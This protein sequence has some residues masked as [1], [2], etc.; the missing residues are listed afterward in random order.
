M[1]TAK[2]VLFI[3]C[4]D[5]HIRVF[6]PIIRR[7]EEH[8]TLAPLVVFLKGV[9]GDMLMQFL[10]EHRLR[11]KI[12]DLSSRPVKTA[13]EAGFMRRFL[14]AVKFSRCLFDINKKVKKLFD[15][16]NPVLVIATNVGFN[17]SYFFYQ[18][19]K[20]GIPSLYVPLMMYSTALETEITNIR[21]SSLS[22]EIYKRL[23]ELLRL[24]VHWVRL[25][26][27]HIS[28]IVV[29]SENHKQSLVE[30]GVQADR[31][32]VTGSPAHDKIF[33]QVRNQ[34]ESDS[35][36]I[37]QHLAIEKDKQIILYTSQPTAIHEF[38]T[39]EEQRQ[40]TGNI[41]KACSRFTPYKLVIKLHPRESIDDYKYLK[42]HPLRDNFRVVSEKDSDLYDLLYIARLV[43]TQSSSTGLD[44]ILFDKDM[45]V[46]D[47]LSPV[48]D[49]MSYIKSGAAL[50]VYKED[51]LLPTLERVLSDT[52]IQQ[53][54]RAK[55]K[56]FAADYIYK[57]DGESAGR[58]LELIHTMIYNE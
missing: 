18:A 36:R 44:A 39:V 25:D 12:L 56:K 32:V 3:P 11:Y 26:K 13:R 57:A 23:Q 37:Y 45:I 34:S 51:D 8:H 16:L 7:M 29:W 55:R 50:G 42:N 10:N 2:N 47:Y 15:K 24:P 28:K 35:T 1:K 9:H 43:V 48:Q 20:R 4:Y 27:G 40:F 22:E 38:C 6:A 21:K 17:E 46:I 5:G 52:S 19:R 30:R 33:Q 49:P 14:Y 54:L 53:E 58:I 31:L 41:I